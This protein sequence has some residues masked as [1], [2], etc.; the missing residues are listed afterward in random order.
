M[1]GIHPPAD[2]TGNRGWERG[3][4][5]TCTPLTTWGTAPSQ[6]SV[7]PAAIQANAAL[8]LGLCRTPVMA[9]VKADGFGMGAVRAARAALAGGATELGVA[10]CAEAIELRRA[11]I[12]EPILA[13]VLHEDAPIAEALSCGIRLAPSSPAQVRHIAAVAV[14]QQVVA[15]V[16]L[17]VETG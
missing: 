1:S 4:M 2:A 17:E 13:W 15:E 8:M 11:G 14:Q 6:L 16:E 9:V 7:S 5:E 3:Y 12:T 10:T